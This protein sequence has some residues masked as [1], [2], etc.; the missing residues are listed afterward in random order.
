MK[1]LGFDA[2]LADAAA[3]EGFAV[4]MG[5]GAGH[6]GVA[7]PDLL[8]GPAFLLRARLPWPVETSVHCAP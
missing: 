6:R 2:G 8:V 5:I 4:S 3:G 1:R 7:H